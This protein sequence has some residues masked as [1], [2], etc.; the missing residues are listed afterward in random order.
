M[1]WRILMITT[2]LINDI[3]VFRIEFKNHT[4][5]NLLTPTTN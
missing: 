1:K 2:I 5:I 4:Q 3:H